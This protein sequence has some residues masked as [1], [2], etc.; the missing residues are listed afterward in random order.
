M[1][2]MINKIQSAANGILS[3]LDK[4]LLNN[5]I[6]GTNTTTGSNVAKTI[7]I[8]PDI[9]QLSLGDGVTE[10]LSDTVKNQFATGTPYVV[11]YNLMLNYF[12]QQAAKGLQFNGLDTRIESN[13][14]SFFPDQYVPGVLATNDIVVVSPGSVKL[15]EFNRFTGVYGGQKGADYF[16]TISLPLQLTINKV[17]PVSFD[18]QLSYLPCPEATA[19]VNDYYG[20]PLTS[21]RGWR[22]TLSKTAGLFQVPSDAYRTGDDL[23]G[24]NGVLR[25]SITNV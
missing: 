10:I 6:I 1:G 3:A 12:H 25:Y 23:L 7:N 21:K 18:Y 16:G 22:L 17:I 20:T 4:D 8:D 5:L 24:V 9:T 14:F 15:V 19:D 2:E 13:G 11:G